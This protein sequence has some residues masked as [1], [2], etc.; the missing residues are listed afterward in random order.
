MQKVLED[1][2]VRV[3]EDAMRFLK[4][5]LTNKIFEDVRPIVQEYERGSMMQ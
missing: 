2:A 1:F 4:K 5:N 3:V